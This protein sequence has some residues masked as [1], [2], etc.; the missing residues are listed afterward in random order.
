MRR[1]LP[2]ANRCRLAVVGLM[3]LASF[4]LA[5]PQRALGQDPDYTLS[6]DSIAAVSGEVDARVML[7]SSG[8]LLAGWSY[9]ICNDASVVDIVSV[10][11]GSTSATIKAGDPPDF[12]STVTYPGEGWTTGLVIDFFGAV[13]LS[14]GTGYELNVATY[15]VTGSAGDT[16]ELAFCETIGALPV[17][18]VVTVEGGV[19]VTPTV[20]NGDVEILDQTF[21]YEIADQSVSYMGS[22]ANVELCATIEEDAGNVGYPNDVRAFSMAITHDSSFLSASSVDETGPLSSLNGGSGPDFFGTTILS[23]GVTIG[24]VF[25]YEMDEPIQFATAQ[26]VA[27]VSYDTQPGVL[28]G[29]SPQNTNVSF[30]G[31][32]GSPEVANLVVVGLSEIQAVA[33]SGTIT[34]QPGGAGDFIRG[35]TNSDGAVDVADPVFNL[36]YQFLS[37]PSTCLDAQ[38]SN[39]DGTVDISDPVYNLSFLFVSGPAIP[40]PNVCGADPTPDTLECDMSSCP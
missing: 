31:G 28:N 16:S 14:P 33:V 4:G 1:S 32:L 2:N 11:E 15:S 35:D 37:G 12:V 6:V 27:C 3:A 30:G 18:V 29:V 22:S 24:A 20:D 25:A 13:F 10:A 17:A 23:N 39:D 36:A 34:F 7:D 8:S 9:G 5:S 40:A 38:D 26:E 21:Y 19:S